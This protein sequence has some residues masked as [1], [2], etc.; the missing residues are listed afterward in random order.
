MK[1]ARMGQAAQKSDKLGDVAS[2]RAARQARRYR[3]AM[4]KDFRTFLARH[5]LDDAY[6]RAQD[7]WKAT[8]KPYLDS[9]IFKKGIE[10]EMEAPT[11]SAHQTEGQEL[12]PEQ[13]E[14]IKNTAPIS[15]LAKKFLPGGEDWTDEKLNELGN[16]LGND[17]PSA[18][19]TCA[20]FAFF[21]ALP[22]RSNGYGR[23]GQRLK[24]IKR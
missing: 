17:K 20:Q 2:Q 14:K 13:L 16:L 1:K 8:I 19:S 11:A 4:S 23:I 6:T 22:G 3:A 21:Q 7:N 5:G 10:P 24:E 15:K 12:N 18:V 9:D